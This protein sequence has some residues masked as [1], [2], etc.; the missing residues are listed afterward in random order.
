MPVTSETESF[1]RHVS[2]FR[3]PVKEVHFRPR[4]LISLRLLPPPLSPLFVLKGRLSHGLR[5]TQ[6]RTFHKTTRGCHSGPHH[7]GAFGRDSVSASWSPSCASKNLTKIFR[8][9]CFKRNGWR[10]S[11]YMSVLRPIFHFPF[12]GSDRF[13]RVAL[14]TSLPWPSSTRPRATWTGS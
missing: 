6:P 12:S 4:R 13:P 9:H 1:L 8:A 10:S 3:Q 11:L 2:I 14:A 7:Q 5:L